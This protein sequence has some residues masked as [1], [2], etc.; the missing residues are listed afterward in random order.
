VL[1]SNAH[2]VVV[3]I[4]SESKRGREKDEAK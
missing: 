2:T 3:S 1:T 4:G